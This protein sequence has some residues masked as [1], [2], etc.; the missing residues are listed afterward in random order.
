LTKDIF[1]RINA[2]TNLTFLIEKGLDDQIEEIKD[3]VTS[4]YERLENVES[5][6]VNIEKKAS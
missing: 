1:N 5:N 3:V 4:L 6:V 2:N